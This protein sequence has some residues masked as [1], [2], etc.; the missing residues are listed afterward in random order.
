MKRN[1]LLIFIILI[2]TLTFSKE[3]KVNPDNAIIYLATIG[4][5]DELFLRWGHFAIIVD[6]ENRKDIL[7]D[8][9]NFSFAKDDF[10]TQF[11]RGIM[12]YSKNRK[13]ADNEIG[14]YVHDNRSVT[15]QELN[16]TPEQVD[17]S[18]RK[19][20]IDVREENKYYQYDHYYNNC[21][22]QMSDFLDYLTDGAFYKDTEVLTDRSFRDLSRDY[23]N[24]NYLNNIFITFL[25]GSKVEHNITE[26]EGMFLPDYTKNRANNVLI[27]DG[28]G[29]LKPLI[30]EEILIYKSEDRD[31]VIVNSKPRI[32]ESIII[33]LL[34]TGITFVLSRYKLVYSISNTVVGLFGGITGSILFFMAFFTG[35]YYIH[36]NWNLILVNPLTFMLFIGGILRLTKKLKSTGDKI[37]KLYINGSLFLIIGMLIFKAL[38][39]IKQDNGEIIALIAPIFLVSYLIRKRSKVI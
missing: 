17:I 13:D 4:P 24:S 7:F 11:I 31:P 19:L 1:F 30:K 5:G 9:G 20:Y 12:I 28:N 37:I 6:Y 18:I 23:V 15:L 21:V 33:G 35:H 36:N 3:K 25:L 32:I 2:S 27:P 29:G 26:K 22:S 16:L 38:G 10:L 14:W 39:L 34:L 8:Y